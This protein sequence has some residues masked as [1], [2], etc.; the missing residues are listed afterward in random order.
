[1]SALA[2]VLVCGTKFGRI[3]LA[4][5]SDPTVPFELAG[6]LAAGSERSRR[7]ARY[8]QVPLLTDPD[9]VP[10]GIDIAC[11]VVGAGINAGPGAI[12]AQRLMARGIHVLQEHPLDQCELADCLRT[13]HRHGVHYAINTHYPH[14]LPVRH[15]IERAQSLLR[16]QEPL[17]VDATC[18][19]QVTY[20]LFDILSRIFDRLRP[21][22]FAPVSTAAELWRSPPYRCVEGMVAGVPLTLR[23]QQEMDVREPDNYA[24][25]FHRIT[26]GTEGGH[27]TLVNTHGPMVWSPRPH[28]PAEAGDV[29]RY[30]EMTAEH[31]GH[32]SAQV[33]GP[34]CGST[35]REVLADLWPAAVRRALAEFAAGIG[36]GV[37]LRGHGQH[38]LALCQLTREVTERAGGVRLIAGRAP[39]ILSG[40]AVAALP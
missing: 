28:L 19:F 36:A 30:D 4:A 33:L 40:D 17:Y 24:H 18:A 25:L 38:Q 15:F 12:L 35:Y 27:L 3:Y 9:Q 5:V 8:Y 14:V 31:L 29:V 13:A 39:D 34:A 11:V 22:G 26:L 10:D 37:D 32:P 1:M 20:T 21:W 23:V 6:I 2:R 7:C 16:R